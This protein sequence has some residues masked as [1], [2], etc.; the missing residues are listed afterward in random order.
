MVPEEHEDELVAHGAAD[1]E[2][3]EQTAHRAPWLSS[4]PVDRSRRWG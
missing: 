3:G 2:E 4:P 1:G